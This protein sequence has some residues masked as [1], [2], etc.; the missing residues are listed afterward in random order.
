MNSS[1]DAGSDAENSVSSVPAEKG[2][3]SPPPHLEIG[4]ATPVE[5]VNGAGGASDALGFSSL[6]AAAK[7]E[8]GGEDDSEG[9]QGDYQEG[10][11]RFGVVGDYAEDGG[12]GGGGDR[13]SSAT[14]ESGSGNGAGERVPRSVPTLGQM[15]AQVQADAIAAG[16]HID[17]DEDVGDGSACGG[18]PS[19]G[20]DGMTACAP[21]NEAT[22]RWTKNE[23]DTFLKALRK[24]GK[25]WK[26]VAAMVKTRTVVQPPRTHP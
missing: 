6:L 15:A 11:S 24:Y 9:A 4:S 20:G 3:Q 18:S 23:H 14:E 17:S 19:G 22:G 12:K 26:K 16:E 8:G 21:G 5:S 10:S 2:A 7:T 13:S 25:E 1:A